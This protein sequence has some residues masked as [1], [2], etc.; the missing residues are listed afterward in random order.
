M[1]EVRE[2]KGGRMQREFVKFPLDLY[3]GNPFFV[4][5]LW[6]DEKRIFSSKNVYYDTCESVYFN[7]YRDGVMVGRISGILQKEANKKT[8]ENRVRF[9]RFD[10]IDDKE[11]AHAL[12]DAVEKWAKSKGMDIVCGP[13]GFS[14]LEREGLLIE[15]FDE[16]AT[17]E[18]QYNYPYYAKL[19]EDCGYEKEV[20]WV[21]F[22]IF[23]P[24]EIDPKLVNISNRV[25]ER[26]NLHVAKARSA[27][28]F[29][30]KY[31]N[32][33][34]HVLDEAYRELYGT[35]DFSDRM[36]KQLISQFKLI[37]SLDFVS[38]ILDNNDRVVGFG[39]GFPSLAKA[40]QP[41]RGRLLPFGIFRILRAVKSPRILDLG[42]I[43]VLPEYQSKGVSGILM[44]K[45]MS[46]M[47]K[48]KVDYCETNLNLE[49]NLKV[50]AQ[51]K[52]FDHTQHKRRRSFQKKI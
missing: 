2:V 31:K 51:W 32:G 22:K 42:L 1:V 52:L 29:I 15:G 24:K 20:D 19:I 47:I 37:I 8:K 39:L 7:A 14:D 6:S 35:V 25:L 26:Y 49:D 21:E 41:S 5:P 28:G 36:K 4:P 40:V 27:R 12:F 16:L 18:E 13:L 11:V 44:T 38:A 50:Q 43:A 45:M 33:I 46:E 10:S 48:Y 3:E 23:P 34:F 9:T 17:F 30:R